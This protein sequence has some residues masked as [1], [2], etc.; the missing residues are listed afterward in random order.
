M[1]IEEAR[2]KILSRIR[3]SQS[4]SDHKRTV[5]YIGFVIFALFVIMN[6]TYT[7]FEML[8]ALGAP[9]IISGIGATAAF[10]GALKLVDRPIS[11]RPST[12]SK[13]GRAVSP[14]RDFGPQ[15]A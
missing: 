10:M 5:R 8:R 14:V 11:R 3:V 9:D 13:V 2:E 4:F 6:T 1:D 15:T 12:H 7:A